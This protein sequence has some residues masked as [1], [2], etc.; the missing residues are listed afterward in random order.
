[1]SLIKISNAKSLPEIWSLIYHWLSQLS[2]TFFHTTFSPLANDNL[3]ILTAQYKFS[4]TVIVSHLY[5][6]IL[7]SVYQMRR[8]KNFVS[9]TQISTVITEEFPLLPYSFRVTLLV[10]ALQTRWGVTLHK[11]LHVM[12]CFKKQHLR[13]QSKGIIKF[14]EKN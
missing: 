10:S 11:H 2:S 3:E 12:I 4:C 14:L 6:N 7:T 9:V 5:L 13:C 8:E 1:M